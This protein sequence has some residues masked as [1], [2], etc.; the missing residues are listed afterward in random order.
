M[1]E[2]HPV[3]LF[4]KTLLKFICLEIFHNFPFSIFCFLLQESISNAT[5]VV[6]R[7]VNFYLA[8]NYSCEVTADAPLFVTAIAY[9]QMQIYGK[10]P[11]SLA[12]IIKVY[13]W[14]INYAN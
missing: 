2:T 9:Y 5:Q 14:K 1:Q 10:F 3:L 8:G 11:L 4:H 13:T 7:D 12:Y 6:L